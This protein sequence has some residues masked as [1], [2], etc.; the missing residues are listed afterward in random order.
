VL[1]LVL[2][3]IRT[4][5]KEDLQA[6]V[7]ELVYGELLTPSVDPWIQHISSPSSGSTPR[8]PA[9]FVHPRLPPSGHNA[10][11]FG[12]PLQRPLPRPV[13]ERKDTVTP[14]AREAR[15][16][17]DRIKPAYILN[18]TDRG[19]GTFN[20]PVDAAPTIASPAT[21][22][23]PSTRT[24]RSGRHIHFPGRFNI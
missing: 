3:G 11:G 1:P 21:P 7:A 8:L 19:N 13:T 22:S 2:F 20:P 17:V 9:T 4:A 12:A 16:R 6:S 23:W 18:G 15:H 5:F 24:T 14:R 10:P